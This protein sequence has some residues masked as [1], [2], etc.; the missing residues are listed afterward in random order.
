[1]YDVNCKFKVNSYK[2]CISNPFSPLDDQY[3]AHLK[4]S[5]RISYLVNV[6]HGKSHK[7]ECSDEHS[8]RNTP[9][10]GMV[11]G[12][13]IESGWAKLNRKQYTTREMDAGARADS[14]TVHMIEHNKEKVSKLSKY[15]VVNNGV[16]LIHFLGNRLSKRLEEAKHQVDLHTKKLA[17]LEEVLSDLNPNIVSRYHEMYKLRGGE[18][19][20]PD[21]AK[22]SCVLSLLQMP[23]C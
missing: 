5:T 9:M 10:N 11:T 4:D 16:D 15:C 18:Q 12:E 19:F 7:P 23:R 22:F 13:E 17:E 3:K 1:M 2:R 14:I 21:P 20:R 6:W 8:L